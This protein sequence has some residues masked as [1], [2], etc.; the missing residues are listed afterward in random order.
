MPQFLVNESK[1]AKASITVTPVGLG[2]TAELYLVSDKVKAATSGQIAFNSTGDPQSIAFP[3]TMPSTAGTYKVY[4]DIYASGIQVGAYVATEDV[5]IIVPPTI[6][7]NLA[8]KV[9]AWTIKLKGTLSSLGSC[10]EV[11][12]SFE[13]QWSTD[14]GFN[15]E[16]TPVTM[17]APGDFSATLSLPLGNA[18]ADWW[19][20]LYRAKARCPATVL[21]NTVMFKTDVNGITG[22]WLL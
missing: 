18:I 3:I 12:V 19:T 7:T 10:S 11:A 17:T 8:E 22:S 4:L 16:T 2:C 20:Y 14:L 5:T 6:A 13:I 15:I 9:A 21:G 1:I